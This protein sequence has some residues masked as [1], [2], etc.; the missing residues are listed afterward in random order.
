[1]GAALSRVLAAHQPNYLPWLGVFHKIGQADVWVIADDVQYSRHG[2]TNRNRIRTR[3]GWQWLTVPVL[4]RGKGLQR[5]CEVEIDPASTWKR[6]HWEALRWNYRKASFFED[7]A[8]FLESVYRHTWRRLVDVNLEMIRYV[9]RRMG[10]EVEICMGSKLDLRP[11]RNLRLIDMAV[12]C[13]CDIYL[14][15]SGGSREYL[16]Q[17]RFHK[18][19]IECRFTAFSHPTYA[20]CFPGFEEKMSV[21]DLLLNCGEASR[22]VLFG[23]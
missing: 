8:E 23:L 3:E 11:E 1:M 4:T 10:I 20:Q 5:I 9:M 7:H 18:A 22:E 19:G 15:G 2:L 6:K 21:L 12:L 16:E 17:E 14:S 13:G